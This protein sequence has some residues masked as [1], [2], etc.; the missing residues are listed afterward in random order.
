MDKAELLQPV[1]EDMAVR[2]ERPLGWALCSALRIMHSPSR[3]QPHPSLCDRY[4]VTRKICWELLITLEPR[5]A[6]ALV[7][8]HC[9]DDEAMVRLFNVS[10]WCAL[11]HA[12]YGVQHATYGVQHGAYGVQ[13]GAYKR[14]T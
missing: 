8:K 3:N 11:Q 13:H 7:S 6:R 9:K 1:D 5:G 12:A 10:A 4:D 14:L 2:C